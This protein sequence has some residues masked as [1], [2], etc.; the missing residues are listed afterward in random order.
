MALAPSA[1]PFSKSPS[2]CAIEFVTCAKQTIETARR[3][4]SVEGRSFHL[5]G[6]RPQI[7]R[8]RDRRFCLAIG[9]IRRPGRAA[10]QFL[11]QRSA[12]LLDA[13]QERHVGRFGK[14][15]RASEV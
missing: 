15:P 4:E 14:P 8:S 9:S 1:S 2:V 3:A 7:A 13:A 12:R 5:D 11:R 10:M 6:E